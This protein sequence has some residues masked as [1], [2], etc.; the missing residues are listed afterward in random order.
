MS[1]RPALPPLCI[2]AD[3]REPHA[4]AGDHESA[5]FNPWRIDHGK[6]LAIPCD[7]VTLREG[8]YGLPGLTVWKP[9]DSDVWQGE[10][11]AV[12]ERKAMGDA[13]STVIGGATDALGEA[14]ANRDRFAEELRRMREYAFR[15]VVIEG[16]QDD[17]YQI[18][19][20]PRRR[21]NP[22]SVIASYAAFASRFG[23]QVWWQDATRDEEGRV[24]VTA[25]RN[26]EW[27]VG[28][29][30]ARIWDEYVGGPGCKKARE[31]GDAMPWIGRGI[32]M[33]DAP[34]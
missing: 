29:V 12:I 16:S 18:A 19:A 27:Y 33:A 23:V 7:R 14:T 25:R 28:T 22:V 32:T 4:D 34:P 9:L 11:L 15:S 26:A 17:V 6:G 2:L 1:K 5:L 20:D 10:P 30:F 31:R 13:I 3:S 21:F 24:V 8:D